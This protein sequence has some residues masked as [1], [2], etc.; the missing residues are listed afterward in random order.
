MRPGF[1]ALFCVAILIGG[2]GR[3]ADAETEPPLCNYKVVLE[4]PEAKA[5]E[6]AVTCRK[7]ALGFGFAD[8]FPANW[9]SSFTDDSGRTLK[10]SGV[11]WRSQYGKIDRARYRIDLDGM[12]RAEDD[13][14]SAKR[15][16]RS[17][18]VDLS[19]IIAL[20]TDIDG[21]SNDTI[22]AIA[23]FAPNGGAI[24]TSLPAEGAVHHV[25]ARE[26]DF[27]AALVLGGFERRRIH[28]PLPFSLGENEAA[29]AAKNPQ[30][31]IDLIV[32]DGQLRASTDEVA[33]WVHRT[34]LA[35]ADLWRGFPVA[36]ST[37]VILPT[38][39]RSNVPFGRV[40]STGGILVLALVGSEIEP[41]AL[42]DEWVLIHEFIHLGT[43][44]IRDTGAWLNEGI[45]TYLEPIVRYRAGWRS[46]E[47]V[48]EEW[49]G[50]MGRGV[51]P[52]T[53]GL[54]SG[55]PYWGGA[56]FALMADT[57]LRKL[58]GGRLGL[59]HCLRTILAEAGDIATA[60]RT[61]PTLAL[62]DHEG[63]EP[64]LSRMAE[65][66]LAGAP[67]D[68]G[69]LFAALGVR[70]SGGKIE[71]DDAAPLADVRRWL[72]DGSSH[73]QIKPIAIPATP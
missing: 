70:N 31:I 21:A 52:M 47:S 8:D 71:L 37:V 5:V 7:P 10:R 67:V 16:G 63:P 38:P 35:N 49:I 50:W 23:F 60:A 39:R 28:V 17:V 25:L 24:A 26:V 58:T 51:P 43:P 12:A 27:A 69:G 61:L 11:A 73:A 20:P 59:E 57:E 66:H 29:G 36:R 3:S 18:M 42:Y 40:I 4:D 46:A 32:M 41:R 64:V 1:A 56:L 54:S 19:G 9:I 34:A 14:D 33:D 45:A 65:T 44:F 55:S 53:R 13:Y 6:V 15:S 30:G 48:W 68:L 72:L 22:L 2:S 62:C